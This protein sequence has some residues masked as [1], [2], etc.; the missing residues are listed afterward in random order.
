MGRDIRYIAPHSLQHVVDVVAQNRYLLSPSAQVNDRYL[1]V[2]GKAQEKY[3]MVICAVVV[4]SNH[5]HLLVRP[6]DGAH[7]AA[8]MCF[9]KTNLAKEIGGRLRS[10]KGHFFDRRYHSTTISDEESAQARVFRYVLSN[11]PKEFLVDTVRQWPGVHCAASLID[12]TSLRGRWYDRSAEYDARMLCGE[13]EVDPDDFASEQVVE[14]SPLPCWEHLP[15]ETWRRAVEE[16]VDAIDQE[17]AS[18]RKATGKTSLGV[19]KVLAQDPYHRPAQVSKSPKPRF[20]VDSA[21]VLETMLHLWSEVVRAF[22]KAAEALRAGDR[23][24]EF[25]EGTFPPALPFVSFASVIPEAR[26]HPS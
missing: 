7:L 1:G 20:H 16:M 14:L 4:L 23:D 9:L 19:S 17:A 18:Q 2:L 3:E 22:H 24:V 11:G 13:T 10:W 21:S 5:A 6:R 15:E 26:G 8:F 12:G 25:P